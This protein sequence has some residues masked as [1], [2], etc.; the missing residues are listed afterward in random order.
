MPTVTGTDYEVIAHGADLKI[1]GSGFGVATDVT[2][3]GVSQDFT[4]ISDSEIV[5]KQVKDATPLDAQSVQVGAPD[6][7]SNSAPATVVHLVINELDS[8]TTSGDSA[9]FVEVGAGVANVSLEGYTLV[10]FNGA[11]ANNPAYFQVHLAAKTNSVSLLLTGPVT[12]SSI[13]WS[14]GILQNG[15]DAVAIYQGRAASFPNGFL[16]TTTRL[17][18]ALVYDTNDSDDAA[19]LQALLGNG[20]EAVQINEAANGFGQFD[21]II[22]CKAGRLDGQNFQ[23]TNAPTNLLPSPGT[24]NGC[25]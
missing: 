10:F 5:V 1:S 11:L 3:G 12:G 21:S 24:A 13:P 7:D 23:I 15:A 4:I 9:E 14:N 25:P 8:D 18:D 16:P 6:G 20:A 2:I 19:L 22:R 17:L